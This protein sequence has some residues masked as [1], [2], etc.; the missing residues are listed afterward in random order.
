MKLWGGRFEKNTAALVED[1]HSSISFDRRLYKH[2]IAGSIA[3]R[4][5]WERSAY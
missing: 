3:M 5:C 2:D 4:G 1:F